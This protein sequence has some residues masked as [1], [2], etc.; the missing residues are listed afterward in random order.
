MSLSV[1]RVSTRISVERY[2]KMVAAG[3]LT[4]DDRVELIEGDIL[5]RAPIGSRH[6]AL[7][8]RLTKLFVRGVGDAAEV[9]VGGPIDL[10]EFSEPQPDLSLLRPRADYTTRIPQPADALLVVEISDT[11]LV[12]DRTTKLALYAGA[13]IEEYWIVD[14]VGERIAMY[15]G[16][17]ANGYGER[18]E[19]SGTDVASPRALPDLRI[20]VRALF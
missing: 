15:R 3:V 5:D 8:V 1:E 17:M 11:T 6:A 13:G 14:V 7:S 9:S 10:G 4:R 18:L 19:V 2:Q 16:P 12:F 20:E